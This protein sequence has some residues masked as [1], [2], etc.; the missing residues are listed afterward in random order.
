MFKGQYVQRLRIRGKC[1][2]FEKLKGSLYAWREKRQIVTKSE[3]GIR[4]S[5]L[6][7]RGPC[8]AIEEF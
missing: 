5:V 2:S 3:A 4:R 6:D 1:E 8:K 7:C